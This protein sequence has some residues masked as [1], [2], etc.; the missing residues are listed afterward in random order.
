MARRRE[1]MH[2]RKSARKK[3]T[4][5]QRRRIDLVSK[6]FAGTLMFNDTGMAKTRPKQPKAA[7]TVAKENAH[8]TR[9]R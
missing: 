3:I 5:K 6:A 8:R 7:S 9:S 2:S 4:A 1:R